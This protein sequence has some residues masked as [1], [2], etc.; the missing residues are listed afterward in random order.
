MEERGMPQERL[1]MRNIRDV[2]RLDSDGLSNRQI[3]A[4]LSVSKT[5][6]RNCLR[7]AAARRADRCYAGDAVL[8]A[9]AVDAGR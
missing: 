6:I 1:P 2:L 9:A 3:G 8:S 7:R 5:T 4:S